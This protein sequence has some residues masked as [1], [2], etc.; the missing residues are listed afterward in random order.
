MCCLHF[1]SACIFPGGRVSGRHRG[2][3]CHCASYCPGC[4]VSC[5]C[6]WSWCLLVRM[7]WH[8]LVSRFLLWLELGGCGGGGGWH[9][10]L[11]WC[12]GGT[13]DTWKQ[14][15]VIRC[16]TQVSP[17][18]Y[19]LPQVARFPHGPCRLAGGWVVLRSHLCILCYLRLLGYLV[20]HINLLVDE[21]Y[22]G[23]TCVLCVTQVARLPHGPYRLTS[24]WVVLRSHLCILCYLRLLGYHV[25]HINLLVDE[26]Y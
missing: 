21:W 25:D 16:C 15:G 2:G 10:G 3:A 20:H 8:L 22:P 17:L 4:K 11:R 24:G 26:W 1:P 13:A 19:V 23:L 18:Y 9:W 6:A 7:S 5:L 12:V 14:V